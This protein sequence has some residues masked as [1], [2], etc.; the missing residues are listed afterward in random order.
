MK[1]IMKKNQNKREIEEVTLAQIKYTERRNKNSR[2][3]KGKDGIKS[4][5]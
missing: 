2:K 1:R 5:K 4:L 3:G